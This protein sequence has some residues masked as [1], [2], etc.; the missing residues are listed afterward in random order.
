MSAS[1]IIAEL[2]RLTP[3][4]LTLIK[5]KVEEVLENRGSSPGDDFLLRVAGTAEGLPPDLAVNHDHYLYG[6]P[7][8]GEI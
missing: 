1:E 7:R 5:N 3:A 6:R 2:P 8:R 4:E